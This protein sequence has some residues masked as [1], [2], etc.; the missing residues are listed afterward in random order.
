MKNYF[1]N[2]LKSILDTIPENYDEIIRW[3]YEKLVKHNDV[4][5]NPFVKD[6][7]HLTGK[8]RDLVHNNCYSQHTKS[9]Y[10]I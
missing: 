6:H 3:L 9:T 10:L 1:K 7:C 5:E 8:F 4:K 2:E